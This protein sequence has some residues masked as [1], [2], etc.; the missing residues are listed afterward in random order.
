MKE[1][2]KFV[3]DIEVNICSEENA[4]QYIVALKYKLR[5][6]LRVQNSSNWHGPGKKGWISERLVC[7]RNVNTNIQDLEEGRGKGG[8]G[9]GGQKKGNQG[10]SQAGEREQHRKGGRHKNIQRQCGK[11]TNCEMELSYTLRACKD[12]LCKDDHDEYKF[13][14][15]ITNKHNHD[16]LESDNFYYED[17]SKETTEAILNIFKTGKG[18]SKAM[19]LYRTNLKSKLGPIGYLKIAGNR[20]INPDRNYF[21]NL[22]AKYCTIEMGSINGP[23]AT[24][25]VYDMV[26]E[27]NTEVGSNLAK[28]TFTEDKEMVVVILDPMVLRVHTLLKQ[29]GD[30]FVKTFKLSS[31]YFVCP[32]GKQ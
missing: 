26:E 31:K 21:F 14:M 8:G 15:R 27:Y 20:S 11:N 30:R 5:T 7:N 12:K 19:R 24:K 13:K 18:P 2:N 16:V 22:Y 9:W 32:M 28:L 29:S 6:Q 17:V 4:N 1:E 25:K 23:D 3:T 10:G